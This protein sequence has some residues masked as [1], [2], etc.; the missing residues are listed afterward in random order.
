MEVKHL[1]DESNL[2]KKEL[3]IEKEKRHAL[4]AAF[5]RMRRDGNI[6]LLFNSL[7]SKIVHNLCN[8]GVLSMSKGFTKT[9]NFNDNEMLSICINV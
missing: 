5:E 2:L 3:E 8:K 6:T 7:C 9:N 1:Q 4:E